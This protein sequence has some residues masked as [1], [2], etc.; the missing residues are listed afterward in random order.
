MNNVQLFAFVILPVSIGA[1]GW[2]IAYF[3]TRKDGR[4]VKH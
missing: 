3:T 2:A 4:T 1:L